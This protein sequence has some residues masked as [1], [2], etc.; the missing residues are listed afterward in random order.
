MGTESIKRQAIVLRTAIPDLQVALEDQLADGDRVASR[1]RGSGT[2]TGVLR[3]PTGEV[4]P[5]GIAIEFEEIRID[6][7]VGDRIVESWFLPDRLRL[8]QQLGLVP[9]PREDAR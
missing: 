2:N 1:W 8:W 3:L 6:R 5:T 4:R 9:M 7:F